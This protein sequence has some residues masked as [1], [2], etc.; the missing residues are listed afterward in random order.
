[1]EEDDFKIAKMIRAVFEE[2]DAP[3]AGTVYE[4]PTT[5]HLSAL[6][7]KANSKFFIAHLNQEIVGCCGIYP[8]DGLPEDTV[9][10][11]KFYIASK[12]REQGLGRELMERCYQ[13]SRDFGYQKIYIESMP[14]FAR[15]VSIYHK[16]GFRPLP[17]PL[18]NSGHTGCDIWLLKDLGSD[19]QA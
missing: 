18:G 8:T 3:K 17:A 6:F 5:D 1:M 15:A 19:N 4:D 13:A 14:A 7:K 10:L 12:A 16:Q 9:E 2:F 11:V